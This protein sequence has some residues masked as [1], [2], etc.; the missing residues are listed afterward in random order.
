MRNTDLKIAK[1]NHHGTMQ[2]RVDFGLHSG[3]RR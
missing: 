3:G 1:L 2:F